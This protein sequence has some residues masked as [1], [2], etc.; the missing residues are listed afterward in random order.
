MAGTILPSAIAPPGPNAFVNC[1][2]RE[3]LADSGPLESWASGVLYDNVRID[4][5]GLNLDQS[6]DRSA[7]HRL[8]GRQLR[9]LAVPGRDDRLLPP[10]DGQ[11]LGDRLLGRLLRRRHL[12]SPQRLRPAA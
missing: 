4:G 7:G 12:R 9:A 11:Q 3:S 6:L 2:T 5:N 10:A 1:R 8:V